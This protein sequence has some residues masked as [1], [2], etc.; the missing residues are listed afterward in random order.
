L[1][2]DASE[3]RVNEIRADI[4]KWI[5]NEGAKTYS[6]PVTLPIKNTFLK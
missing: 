3:E 5:K 2:G 6:C 4:L 1:A